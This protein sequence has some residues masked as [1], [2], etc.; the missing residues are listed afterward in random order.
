MGY[1]DN[2]AMVRVDFF[3]ESGKWYATEAVRWIGNGFG[4]S[5]DEK[6]PLMHD[7]FRDSLLKHLETLDGNMRLA[8]MWAVCLHPYHRDA[9]PLMTKIVER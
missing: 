7:Q 1:S 3:K 9:F 4:R 5:Y 8:G 2:P 6:V